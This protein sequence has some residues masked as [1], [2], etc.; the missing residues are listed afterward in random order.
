MR[1]AIIVAA[2]LAIPGL[3]A[4]DAIDSNHTGPDC[5]G[6]TLTCPAGSH[7]ASLGHSS[8]PSVC[9][10]SDVCTTPADCS[11]WYGPGAACVPTRFCIGID[12][13]GPGMSHAVRGDCDAAG[14]CAAY[15]VET[16]GVTCEI[17]SRCVDTRPP[18][19][20]PPPPDEGGCSIAPRAATSGVSS[21]GV[22]AFTLALTFAAV[23]LERRRPRPRSTRASRADA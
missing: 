7:P 8:C 11:E 6:S 18:P 19:P 21:G 5:S 13:S 23:R 22:L 2:C 20:P 12:F 4:A 1:L 15:P 16:D 17:V 9:A 3:A 14:T 10:P